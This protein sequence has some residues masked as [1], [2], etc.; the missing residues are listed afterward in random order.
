MCI[1]TYM[2][3]ILYINQILHSAEE[4]NLSPFD[5]NIACLC[6]SIEIN[7]NKYLIYIVYYVNKDWYFIRADSDRT[8]YGDL[9][10]IIT[11]SIPELALVTCLWY[12][13]SLWHSDDIN[14]DQLRWWI[15]AW[16]YQAITWTNVAPLSSDKPSDIHLMQFPTRYSS[17]QSLEL[18]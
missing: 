12:F 2:L 4:H 13:N 11:H 16:R 6:Q 1:Y 8:V 10:K 15:V 9:G 3:Y 14:L 5:L 18:A 7:N 17:H